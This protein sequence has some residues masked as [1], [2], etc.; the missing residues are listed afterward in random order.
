MLALIWRLNI[1][2]GD[3]KAKSNFKNT[4]SSF[5]RLLGLSANY[6]KLKEEAKWISSKLSTNEEGKIVSEVT[7]KGQ[8]LKLFPEQ[9][10]AAMLGD[11]RKIISLNNLPNN[12]AVISVP[13]YYTEAERKSLK[14]A[15]KIAGLSPVK[16]LNENSAICLSYGL[17]RKTELEATVPRYV[18][19]VDF[20][21]SKFS[22]F[23][24]EFYNEKVRIVA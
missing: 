14:D 8:S 21:H 18:A 24:G 13:S 9:V 4:I 22:C 16:L 17:F 7:Y 15:C 3:L 19:F 5:N 20:G 6:P 10:T 2:F 23:V 11:L 1:F 12:E